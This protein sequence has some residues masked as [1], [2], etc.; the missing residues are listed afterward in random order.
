MAGRIT[1]AVILCFG[2]GGCG[3]IDSPKV[4]S[5]GETTVSIQ[6]GKWRN[7]ISLADSYCAKYGRNAVEVSH[8]VFGYNESSTLYVYDCVERP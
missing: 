8:G 6:A 2:L 3:G 4:I 5:G 7:P 1:I